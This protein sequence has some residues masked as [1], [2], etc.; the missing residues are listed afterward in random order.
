MNKKLTVLFYSTLLQSSDLHH[1][2]R[3]ALVG[4]KPDFVKLLLEHGVCLREFLTE[5]TLSDLY[6]HL[7][8]GCVFLRRLAKRMKSEKSRKGCRDTPGQRGVCL[9]HV[10]DEV[11][12]YLGAFTEPIYPPAP[13]RPRI[14]MP[15]D[16]LR[17]T[18]SVSRLER[19]V[20]CLRSAARSVVVTFYPVHFQFPP[21]GPSELPSTWPDRGAEGLL[22]PGRD[23]FLWAILQN[24]KELAEIAWEQVQHANREG[25]SRVWWLCCD[26]KTPGKSGLY[27]KRV[28]YFQFRS[29]QIGLNT[30]FYLTFVTYF[31][32]LSF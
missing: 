12:H 10:S 15:E 30:I 24:K 21:K 7:E 27:C 4:H 8:T 17:V 9:R 1:A 22:D 29:I 28:N 16:D 25:K 6:G 11:R 23:L 31:T 26:L 32:R 5:D 13:S 14:E 2:M 19:P 3:S 20:E 18:V